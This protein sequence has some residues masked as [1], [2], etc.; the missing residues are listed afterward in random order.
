VKS[1]QSRVVRARTGIELIH[2][3]GSYLFTQNSKLETHN[4][5]LR[6][7]NSA[8]FNYPNLKYP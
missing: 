4:C 7:Q 1:R 5:E 3:T 2:H 6:T 8:G